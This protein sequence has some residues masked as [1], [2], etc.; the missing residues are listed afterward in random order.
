MKV[1]TFNSKADW[2]F[3]AQFLHTDPATKIQTPINL[4]GSALRVSFVS[5]DGLVAG[6]ASTSSGVTITDA[7][8]GRVF[9]SIPASSRPDLARFPPLALTGDVYRSVG[10]DEPTEWIARIPATLI[11]GG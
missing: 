3:S 11:L 1:P 7:L 9:V 10:G 2:R 8:Q 6:E 5:P 4:T